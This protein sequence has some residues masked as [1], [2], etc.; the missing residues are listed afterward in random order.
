MGRQLRLPLAVF[1]FI[2]FLLIPVQ[3]MIENP[4]LLLGRFIPRAGWIEIGLIGSYGALNKQDILARKP[5]ITCTLCGDCLSACQ[6][7]SLQYR[8]PGLSSLQARNLY[9]LI[10]ISLHAATLAL[11]R[12]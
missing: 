12:I 9:L 4:M 3:L 6:A 1:L 8:F 10:S 11:A 7:S 5:G 2:L